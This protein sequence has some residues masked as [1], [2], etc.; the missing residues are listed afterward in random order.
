LCPT[1]EKRHSCTSIQYKETT[2]IALL[3]AVAYGWRQEALAVNAA[4]ISALGKELYLRIGTLAEHWHAVG[5][6][7][8]SAVTAYNNAVGTFEGRVMSSARRFRDLKAV[9]SDSDLKQ[10]EQ[11][12]QQVRVMASV[13]PADSPRS[14]S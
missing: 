1:A 2:L 11:I 3:R 8:G 6:R 13:A 4:E 7:L 5:R 9:A 12:D 14:N 10:Q